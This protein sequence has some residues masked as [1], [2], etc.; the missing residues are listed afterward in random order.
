M[1]TT[2][3][4]TG[5]GF[6][7]QKDAKKKGEKRV[8][9]IAPIPPPGSLLAG[10]NLWQLQQV[11]T[12]MTGK[13]AVLRYSFY[14]CY[15]GVGGRGQPK[16]ATDRCCQLHDA[17]YDSLQRHHCDAKQQYYRYSWDRAHLTCSKWGCWKRGSPLLQM[18]SESVLPA[19]RDSWCARL[20]CE[21]DRSLGLCLR[22]SARS[23]KWRYVLY[24]KSKCR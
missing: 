21:C 15:C 4:M 7:K 9:G 3:P 10:G 23:Y 16:D 12:K 17:C 2:Q 1:P 19:D 22:R 6:P 18:E 20:S 13:N 8:S 14:G 5:G 11:I 24:P